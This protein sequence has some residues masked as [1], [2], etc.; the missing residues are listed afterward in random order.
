MENFEKSKIFQNDGGIKLYVRRYA[1]KLKTIMV[2]GRNRYMKDDIRVYDTGDWN[3]YTLYCHIDG[4]GYLYVNGQKEIDEDDLG[5]DDK[6]LYI[7]VTPLL[8]F[9]T[10]SL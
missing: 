9:L 1:T 6:G 10:G 4:T 2:C 7:W 8:C 5:H 3:H